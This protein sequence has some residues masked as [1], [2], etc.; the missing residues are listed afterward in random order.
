MRII[1]YECLESTNITAKEMALSG[2]EHG[3]VITANRQTAGRGR[4]GRSF[5]SPENH[6]LY[7][8]VILHSEQICMK[9]P[10]LITAF[11]AVSVCEAIEAITNIKLQVKWVNDVIYG[12]KKV[13]GILTETV[14]LLDIPSSQRF[15]VGI[16]INI[17]TPKAG[18][19]DDIKNSAGSLFGFE[20]P[21]VTA[22][23]LALEIC[24]RI[25]HPKN[26]VHEPDILEKYKK[27]MFLLGKKV[28]ISTTGDT[29]DAIAE[30][31]DDSGRLVV[32]KD[33]GELLSLFEGDINLNY[34]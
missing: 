28:S 21:P 33:S 19:P 27:R 34:S 13:C 12:G 1:T 10:T 26:P 16:G 7:M 30:D 17:S 29:Y 11:T 2:A 4:Y 3:L 15:I 24:M 23:Q 6:G 5:F 8:S 20:T 31:I 22:Q 18:Y 14:T 9:T 25:A 32:R